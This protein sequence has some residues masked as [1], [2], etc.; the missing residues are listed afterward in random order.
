MA[1]IYIYYPII[2]PYPHDIP[3]SQARPLRCIPPWPLPSASPSG[4][5]KNLRSMAGTNFP[6][7]QSGCLMDLYGFDEGFLMK[8]GIYRGSE[9]GFVRVFQRICGGF[10]IG[11]IWDSWLY[12]QQSR[13]RYF[14]EPLLG[15]IRILPLYLYSLSLLVSGSNPDNWDVFLGYFGGMFHEIMQLIA[16]NW[17]DKF[18]G[19]V[20]GEMT[21]SGRFHQQSC[22]SVKLTMFG[23]IVSPKLYCSLK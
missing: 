6:E 9:E 13:C 2:S 16:R 11:D 19:V 15:K 23:K 21:I 10:K 3:M 18:L 17:T 1:Y 12:Q 8:Y 7:I 4:W 5:A 14:F 20:T 22:A